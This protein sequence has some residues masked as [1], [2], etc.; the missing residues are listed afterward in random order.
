M[1]LWK[2][3]LDFHLQH[4]IQP[5]ELKFDGSS[6]E[7]S[8]GAGIVITSSKGVKTAISFNLAF[9]C[10]NNQAEY[11]ALVI[12]LEVLKDLGARDVLLTE[13]SQLVLK[14]LSGKFKCTSISLA[15]YYTAA[16]QILDDFDEVSFVHVPRLE[17]WEADE[18][19]Q[20]ASGLKMSPELTHK[21]VLIQKR[22]HLSILQ[23]GIQVEIFNLD[24]N[25]AGDW[26]DDIKQVLE[27]PGV[28]LLKA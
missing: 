14:Q 2:N 11:E 19:A 20:I 5:W 9:P 3:I 25:L 17:N 13:D 26:S 22:N 21:M 16:S 12:G 18:L 28:I 4:R 1:G 27:S 7:A 10:T 24:T 15:P 23:R 6:T 8:A